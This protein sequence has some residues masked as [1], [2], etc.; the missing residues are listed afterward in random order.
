[1]EQ[2]KKQVTSLELHQEKLKQELQLIEE[3]NELKKKKIRDSSSEYEIELE[4]VNILLN[5]TIFYLNN[6]HIYFSLTNSQ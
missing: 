5:R 4:K 1:M 2:L 6:K 3:K